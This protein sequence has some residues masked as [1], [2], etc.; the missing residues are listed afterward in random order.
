MPTVSNPTNTRPYAI[1]DKAILVQLRRPLEMEVHDKVFL[2][3]I[4]EQHPDLVNHLHEQVV[5]ESSREEVIIMDAFLLEYSKLAHAFLIDAK[6]H[7]VEFIGRNT[8]PI[9]SKEQINELM[10][11]VTKDAEVIG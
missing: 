10:E 5:D 2:H 11:K 6:F 4:I 9:G 3:N 1:P 8:K 7:I